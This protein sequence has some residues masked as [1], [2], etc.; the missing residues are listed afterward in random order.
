M[1]KT[2]KSIIALI[3]EFIDYCRKKGFSSHT[4]ENYKRY[5]NKFIFWLKE[6]KKTNLK[7]HQLS[8]EDIS[9]YKEFLA[10]YKN[11]KGLH[12]KKVT[13]NYYLIAL[14]A[15]LSYFLSKDILCIAPNKIK[16]SK[17][18]DDSRKV[19]LP[20]LK[21]IEKILLAP[22]ISQKKGLR[23][24]A[25]LETIIFNGFKLSKVVSLNRED[26][27]KLSERSRIWVEK[28]LKTRQDSNKAMFIHYR[29]RKGVENRLTPRSI[30]RIVKK[31]GKI[32]GLGFPITC[33]ILRR[34]YISLL[35]D[36]KG[37]SYEK[38]ISSLS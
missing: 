4:Q 7:P 2:T 5:L 9:H 22:D 18:R 34:S 24:R 14:R 31:Y 33:E 32:S 3:P 19:I 25:L 28:Y 13:Q 30:Q 10:R 6:N 35:K 12:L 29:S 1:P 21:Q 15:L 36:I 37:K 20:N 8:L 11:E 26:V 23:D 17:V 38:D 27:D 16:L